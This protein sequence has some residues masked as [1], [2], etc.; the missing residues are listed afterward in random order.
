MLVVLE[1]NRY[2]Q[3]TPQSQTLAGEIEARAAAFGIAADRA[4][5]WDPDDAACGRRAVRRGGTSR[6][7]AAFLRIDTD[8]LMA[9]SKGDDDR[10]PA[11]VQAYWDR[12]PLVT[13]S[14]ENPDEAEAFEAEARRGSTPRW[15]WPRPPPTPRLRQSDDPDRRARSRGGRPGS[16]RPNASST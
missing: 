16:R 12:D 11:E 6:R 13:F 8:R 5:T 9:H 3:S 7:R 15:P 4:D 1:N 10:D 14:R 2:A